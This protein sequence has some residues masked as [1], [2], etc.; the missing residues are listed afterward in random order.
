[1]NLLVIVSPVDDSQISFLNLERVDGRVR[2]TFSKQ[3]EVKSDM[4]FSV[5]QAS[6]MC[7]TLKN[8]NGEETKFLFE[9][10]INPKRTL[11]LQL[12]E[13][14]IELIAREDQCVKSMILLEGESINEF[15]S[16][17]EESLK[18]TNYLIN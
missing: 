6:V 17:L 12:Y 15:S 14:A 7:A 5:Y 11:L 18:L 4:F 10:I 8:Y 9:C 13:G 1:M 16:Y 2:F 3:G